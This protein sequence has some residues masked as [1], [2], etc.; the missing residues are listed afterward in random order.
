VV[1]VEPTEQITDSV[2][3]FYKG[4]N[5]ARFSAH[6]RQASSAVCPSLF[7]D[8][9]VPIQDSQVAYFWRHLANDEEFEVVVTHIHQDEI[10]EGERGAV[11]QVTQEEE[12][13]GNEAPLGWH[14]EQRA[15]P[16]LRAEGRSKGSTTA[17][18]RLIVDMDEDGTTHKGDMMSLIAKYGDNV[19]LRACLKRTYYALFG[20]HNKVDIEIVTC[21]AASL[22]LKGFRICLDSGR[23]S[24]HLP[25]PGT[26]C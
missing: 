22:K 13:Q 26:C 15:M 9:D 18:N 2:H 25:R 24:F 17:T 23:E 21:C 10:S 19:R 12:A 14:D 5:Q 16:T 4:S 20:S 1:R 11:A 7:G 6:V 8:S 3:L